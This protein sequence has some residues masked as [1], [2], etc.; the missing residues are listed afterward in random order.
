[1]NKVSRWRY[2]AAIIALVLA[3]PSLALGQ[4]EH[5]DKELWQ[6]ALKIH[7][8]SVVMNAAV[9]SA[10]VLI[11]PGRDI[12]KRW[13][14]QGPGTG[15]VDL[16]RLREGG[17]N[18]IWLQVGCTVPRNEKNVDEDAAEMPFR[19][20][21]ATDVIYNEVL[22][23]YPN[24]FE[25]AITVDDVRRIRAKGKIAVLLGMQAGHY[26]HGSVRALRV[27]H[28]L[29][30]QY[31]TLTHSW[32]DELCDSATGEAKWGGLSEAGRQVV[33]EMNRIGM[34][35]DI[36]HATDKASYQTLEMSEG[37]VIASHSNA[38][39]LCKLDPQEYGA[40]A[41]ERNL[42]DD[43]IRRVAATG[44]VINVNFAAALVT[45]AWADA[46]IRVRKELEPL[47]NSHMR[48][49][50]AKYPDDL[51]KQYDERLRFLSERGI[52][53]N[54]YEDV[55]GQIEYIA[56]VAG[57]DHVGIGSDW[58]GTGGYNPRHLEDVS[59][60]PFLTYELLRRGHKEE[61]IKK[62]LGE[63]MLRALTSAQE[64]ARRLQQRSN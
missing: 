64:T 9:V 25:L 46:D 26:I 45:Q 55:V 51:E 17:V 10:Q 31:M 48:E 60:I 53:Y 30:V 47:L 11:R 40:G 4:A 19:G 49:F 20:L 21:E 57:W 27:F 43:L 54:T 52:H 6:R 34:I 12:G 39:S 13:Q 3:R 32:T 41:V 23:K 1:M 29:G 37:P 59:K 56:K 16:P 24:D 62:F 44:G 35:P 33:R 36:S 15:D 42:S 63:N 50:N 58:D 7:S 2:L 38:R 28:R 8:Q 14:G 22:D 18:V 61:D 5:L